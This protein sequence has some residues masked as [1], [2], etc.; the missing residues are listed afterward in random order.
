MLRPKSLQDSN[1][2]KNGLNKVS[3]YQIITFHFVATLQVKCW[4][5]HL[6]QACNSNPVLFLWQAI[7][8]IDLLNFRSQ[9]QICTYLISEMPLSVNSVQYFTSIHYYH[10]PWKTR[11]NLYCW[12]L[13][14]PLNFLPLPNIQI[15]ILITKHFTGLYKPRFDTLHGNELSCSIFSTLKLT[16]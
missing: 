1:I 5:H 11:I 2:T 15:K 14:S 4:L 8:Q 9:R 6:L 12:C 13:I 16:R 3:S 10:C 7:W